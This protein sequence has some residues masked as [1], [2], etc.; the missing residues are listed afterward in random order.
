MFQAKK[1]DS[2]RRSRKGSDR[3]EKKA[4][5]RRSGEL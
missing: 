4:R 3:S 1:K 5:T 2:K